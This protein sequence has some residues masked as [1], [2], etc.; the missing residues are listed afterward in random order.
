MSRR[1]WMV[2]SV[3]L[4]PPI[5]TYS[6]FSYTNLQMHTGLL[7]H[8]TLTPF[9]HLR[10]R[11]VAVYLKRVQSKIT[12]HLTITG[13][14]KMR[15]VAK[16][17]VLIMC[18]LMTALDGVSASTID[19]ENHP[20]SRAVFV[21]DADT[22]DLQLELSNG[23]LLI[24]TAGKIVASHPAN[25][26][27]ELVIRGN[28][29]DNTL[30]I[31]FA[32]GNPIP[33]GTLTFDGINRGTDFDTLKIV[34]SKIVATLSDALNG[35]D[36]SLALSFA[37]GSVSNILYRNI[38]PIDMTGSSA[39]DFVFNLPAAADN[40]ELSDTGSSNLRIAST[41]ATPTFESTD[42][43]APSVSITINGGAGDTL[44]VGNALSFA[45]ALVVN[46][47]TININ[48]D[49]DAGSVNLVGDLSLNANLDFRIGGTT[50]GSGSNEYEQFVVT[51]GVSIVGG[52]LS[53]SQS[54]GFTP[55][56]NDI[57][58][59]VDNDGVDA[60]SGTFSGLPEG[61][62]V[63]GLFNGAQLSITYVGGD[64]NDIALFSQ[65]D[66]SVTKTDGVTTAVPGQAV[67]YTIVANNAGPAVDSAVSLFDGVP[68]ELTCTYTSVA[69]DGATGNTIAGS[70]DLSE[71]L[72]MP[73]GSSV[74]YTVNCKIASDA[75]GT[76]SNTATVTASL[77]DPDG[78][79]NAAT[80]NNTVL[81]PAADISVSKTDSLT[82]ATP[83]GS[84]NYTIIASNAGPSNDPS[85]SL[86]DSLP[87]ELTCTYTS[88]AADGATGNTATGAGDIA[89]TLSMPSGSSVTYTFTCDIDP[90]ATGTLS[91][92]A[93][94]SAS[95]ADGDSDN[96]SATDSDT[97]L[98]PET[99]LFITKTDGLDTVLAGS[100]VTYTIEVTNQGPS[101][102]S[103]GSVTDLLP[104]GLSFVSSASSCTEEPANITCPFGPL[105]VD[106]KV[107]LSF[108]ALVD[109]AVNGNILNTAAVSGNESNPNAGAN[110]ADTT[111][112]WAVS[113]PIPT[114]S[115]WTLILMIFLFA[116][117]GMRL[118][119]R[120]SWRD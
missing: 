56:P 94:V 22:K 26:I 48:G 107:E 51:G 74:T 16:L 70:G 111:R 28:D 93:T 57:F 36:G 14:V 67:T 49:V 104:E 77:N 98:N 41:D 75:T 97:V 66:V 50:P 47:P 88:V 24:S 90:A 71:T 85:V 43:S 78:G 59:I 101:A 81:V 63:P 82:T 72:S 31:D 18:C 73:V 40:A 3:H 83:G 8:L 99:A 110:A 34:N 42:F 58:V 61:A 109:K 45:A 80:D 23:V 96:D 102:S 12:I 30:I 17:C 4:W 29:L 95:V 68:T 117:V 108:V 55:G 44:S 112:V 6:P 89:E 21:A 35:H 7:W 20:S 62:T 60:I 116:I 1:P 15:L 106:S 76:L 2:E 25:F 86:T 33:T 65:A 120:V 64:G 103:G 38:E 32:G 37:D 92:T 113:E 84:L 115:A 54:G 118:I 100:E 5:F 91:N 69:A 39:T 27:T 10:M 13:I 114:L 53:L 52:T 79:N 19:T 119:Q 11:Y 9:I 87:S 46:I 105:S